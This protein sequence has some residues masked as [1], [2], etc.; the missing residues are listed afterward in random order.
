[1]ASMR[2]HIISEIQRIAADS[3]GKAPGRRTFE[4]ET[5]ITNWY[6]VY[7]ARWGDAL[8]EAGFA[9]NEKQA[10]TDTHFLL[11]KLAEAVRA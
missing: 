4:R 6:G 7:W 8:A 3:G 10:K 5:G 2:D 1:M 9:A 11:G